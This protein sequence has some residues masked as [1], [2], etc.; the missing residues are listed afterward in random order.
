MTEGQ[1]SD[2]E[3]KLDRFEKEAAK[4]RELAKSAHASALVAVEMAGAA[5]WR[6]KGTRIYSIVA[7]IVAA[8]SAVVALY[9]ALRD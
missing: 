4:L 9:V 7:M 8:A 2:L 1:P 6:A 3:A 5:N